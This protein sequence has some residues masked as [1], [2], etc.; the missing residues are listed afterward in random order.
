MPG[1]CRSTRNSI[2]CVKAMASQAQTG[3]M[4]L[5]PS[6]PW[7]SSD[8]V[9]ASCIGWGR[10]FAAHTRLQRPGLGCTVDEFLRLPAAARQ[11]D[12]RGPAG[13]RHRSD[14]R[15][16]A[17]LS[18]ERQRVLQFPAPN[19]AG[20]NLTDKGAELTVQAWTNADDAES[21]RADL[22]A[23]L[24]GAVRSAGTAR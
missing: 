7:K 21:V 4:S 3:T 2:M 23:H 1:G 19:V 16:P 11:R 15:R 12:F 13:H 24:V 17:K 20:S 8:I 10:W 18:R 9:R 6:L 14:R 22:V 5:R